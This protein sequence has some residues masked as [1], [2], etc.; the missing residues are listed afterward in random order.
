MKNQNLKNKKLSMK[1]SKGITL[2][3]LI[4][5]IIVLLILAVVAI[6]AVNNTG[7]IQYAQNSAD[8]YK[9]GRDKENTTLGNY[10]DVLKHYK[11]T[12]DNTNPP[13]EILW[14]YA[15]VNGGAL[16]FSGDT[17][18]LVLDANNEV[19][20][21]IVLFDEETETIEYTEE[22]VNKKISEVATISIEGEVEKLIIEGNAGDKI[23][24][25][26]YMQKIKSIKFGEGIQRINSDFCYNCSNLT[27][28][29]LP[30]TLAS[31]GGGVFYGCTSLKTV[32]FTGT[33]EQW[34]EIVWG[35][36]SIAQEMIGDITT[37]FNTGVPK[38]AKVIFSNG[39][40]APLFPVTE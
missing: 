30:S 6:S 14:Y 16:L 33:Q 19:K 4:I 22:I 39:T 8:E 13:E 25:L 37:A 9:N 7:I 12:E 40:E 18:E 21:Y 29:E 1:G 11:P 36:N 17:N 24:E 15:D 23:Q 35:D 27:T 10:M 32:K 26:A 3:A 5:T 20:A 28:V 38:D 34:N 2:V 31:T